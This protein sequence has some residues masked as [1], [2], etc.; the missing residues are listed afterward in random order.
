MVL[1]VPTELLP[2][3]VLVHVHIINPSHFLS[4]HKFFYHRDIGFK[5]VDLVLQWW[6][7][8]W[9][10][11]QAHF[12]SAWGCTTF[13]F[14]PTWHFWWE[15]EKIH[16]QYHI[17]YIEISSN[18]QENKCCHLI[19]GNSKEFREVRSKNAWGA[20]FQAR[21]SSSIKTGMRPNSYFWSLKVNKRYQ[22]NNN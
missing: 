13:H 16:C 6:D 15:E 1:S 18:N 4:Y 3:M 19:D 2:L 12:T 11:W 9:Q 20:T 7:I 17:K 10:N 5:L 14:L 22:K 21:K 8:R